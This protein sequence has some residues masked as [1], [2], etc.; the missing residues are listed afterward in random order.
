MYMAVL[1]LEAVYEIHPGFMMKLFGADRSQI[2]RAK[3]WQ[4]V[5]EQ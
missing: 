4:N 5:S 1:G 3:S 2:K